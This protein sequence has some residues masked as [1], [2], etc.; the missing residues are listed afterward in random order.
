MGSQCSCTN[1]PQELGSSRNIDRLSSPTTSENR[2]FSI[3]QSPLR[4]S[5]VFRYHP[6]EGRESKEFEHFDLSGHH[7]HTLWDNQATQ[8]VLPTPKHTKHTNGFVSCNIH[9]AVDYLISGYI[10]SICKQ[11]H[12]DNASKYISSLIL[13]TS[14]QQK[15]LFHLLSEHWNTT[16]IHLELLFRGT[17]DDVQQLKTLFNKRNTL[18]MIQS[19]DDDIFGGFTSMAYKHSITKH[20]DKDAFLWNLQTSKIF[21]NDKKCAEEENVY[22]GGEEGDVI[23]QFGNGPDLIIKKQWHA[24]NVNQSIARSFKFNRDELIGTK[25]ENGHFKI[26]EIEV[27]VVYGI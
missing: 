19:M 11:Y 3:Q 15:S 10:R 14:S 17:R 21:D 24:H 5:E 22:Y 9:E 6:V 26:K 12:N 13:N 2:R 1:L 20:Y 23:I 27:F 18:W 4:V 7:D 8:D 16:M 25:H